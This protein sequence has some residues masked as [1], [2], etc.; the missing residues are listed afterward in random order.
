MVTPPLACYNTCTEVDNFL[1]TVQLRLGTNPVHR[2][3]VA[4]TRHLLGYFATRDLLGRGV[5]RP[6]V[7]TRER[8]AAERRP[9]RR[10]KALDE[11]ILKHPLNFPNEVTCQVKVR[12]NVKIGAFRL[13]AVDTSKLSVLGQNVLRVLLKYRARHWLSKCLILSSVQGQDQVIKGHHT[14]YT[15][16]RGV[17]HVL[18]AILHVEYNR[19]GLLAIWVHLGGPSYKVRSR[20]CQKFQILKCLILKNKDLFL[21]QNDPR[22]P[23]V[24]FVFLYV[25]L[26]LPKITFD[27]MT[28]PLAVMLW[29]EI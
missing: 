9:M 8:M 4:L 27:C 16:I 10:S 21:R 17:A 1:Y 20:S 13:R 12:S 23:M 11:T 25:V 15:N 22:I 26:N 14:L 5:K 29:N 18:W 28:S 2:H 7:I 19:D 6:H 24:P 3:T